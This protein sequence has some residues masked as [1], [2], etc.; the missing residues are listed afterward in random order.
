MRVGQLQRLPPRSIWVL[1]NRVFWKAEGSTRHLIPPAGS[2]STVT[3]LRALSLTLKYAGD[4]CPTCLVFKK[5][6]KASSAL[7]KTIKFNLPYKPDAR[8]NGEF[9]QTKPKEHQNVCKSPFYCSGRYFFKKINSSQVFFTPPTHNFQL[10]ACPNEGS[11]R[12]N[13]AS[14]PFLPHSCC[15]NGTERNARIK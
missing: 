1:P 14:F 4:A 15:T 13:V 10:L 5:K 9:I 6:C 12:R 11:R 2:P 8:N 7:F 3:P